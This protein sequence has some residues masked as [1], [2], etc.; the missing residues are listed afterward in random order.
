MNHF[1]AIMEGLEAD[2]P[3]YQVWYVPRATGKPVLTWHARRRDGSGQPL[4]A[5][6]PAELAAQLVIHLNH[7]A[8]VPNGTQAHRPGGGSQR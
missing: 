7:Q 5:D 6:S 3:D 1:Q 4:S 2:W 8:G